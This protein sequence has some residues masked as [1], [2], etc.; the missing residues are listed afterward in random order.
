MDSGVVARRGRRKVLCNRGLRPKGWAAATEFN[1]LAHKGLE[2]ILGAR[3]PGIYHEPLCELIKEMHSQRTYF[4]FRNFPINK[5]CKIVLL[6]LFSFGGGG[7][8]CGLPTGPPKL[9]ANVYVGEEA[10]ARIL[11][12]VAIG[13]TDFAEVAKSFYFCESG[14]FNGSIVYYTIDF[15]EKD[16]CLDALEA[17]SGMDRG[18]LA[19]WKPSGYAVVMDGPLF[20]WKNLENVPW[21]LWSV[22]KGL[23]YENVRGEHQVLDYYAV[24][25][26]RNRLYCHHESGGFPALAASPP[27]KK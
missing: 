10:K 14:S 12:R 6:L 24:D 25:L 4:M 27:A 3:H 15:D 1:M 9:A 11:H 18:K 20:Y 8:G 17:L 7:A 5:M 21:D 19:S 26:D 2:P 22:T 16:K 13:K 23:V